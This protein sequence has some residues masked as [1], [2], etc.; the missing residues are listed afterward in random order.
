MKTATTLL[1]PTI[2]ITYDIL[3]SLNSFFLASPEQSE[4]VI[5][6][7]GG[8]PTERLESFAYLG[9]R[10]RVVSVPEKLGP[11]HAR[12]LAAKEAKNEV[13]IFIDYDV[14]ITG[15]IIRNLSTVEPGQ[16]L[17]PSV[18]P[19][20]PKTLSSRFF[21]DVALAP[22]IR[23]E[24]LMAVSACFSINKS[25]YF[26]VEGFDERFKYPAGEDWD[27]FSRIQDHGVKLRFERDWRVFHKNPDNLKAV[28]E[29]AFGYGKNG[30]RKNPSESDSQEV[31][32][33]RRNLSLPFVLIVVLLISPFRFLFFSLSIGQDLLSRLATAIYLFERALI[34]VTYWHVGR[35]VYFPRLSSILR[36]T[37]SIG[38]GNPWPSIVP[39]SDAPLK[40]RSKYRFI[41]LLWRISFIYGVLKIGKNKK[42]SSKSGVSAH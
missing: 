10:L 29:R 26:S 7:D 33:K 35:T 31:I 19:Q 9:N 15:Q 14:V 21:S 4:A 3:D 17:L 5:V 8:G 13:L 16:I 20:D 25:D 23:E 22:K 37:Q 11:A 28:A 42:A 41:M 34:S 27:F 1:I 39:I 36:T 18:H 6:L 30:F 2:K 40:S 12:N 38:T 32:P 24:K